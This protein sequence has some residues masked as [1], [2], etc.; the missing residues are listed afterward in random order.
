MNVWWRP[1]AV[2]AVFASWALVW[3]ATAGAPPRPTATPT[4]PISV[5]SIGR[6]DNGCAVGGSETAVSPWALAALPA[7]LAFVRRRHR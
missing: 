4:P 5:I 6:G 2:A 3:E 7:A 1:S